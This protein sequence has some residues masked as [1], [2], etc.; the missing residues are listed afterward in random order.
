MAH[1]ERM[2]TVA[3]AIQEMA[4]RGYTSELKVTGSSLE[5]IGSDK[6][7]AAN[8]VMVREHRRFEGVSDPDDTSVLYAIEARD[9][10][11][12]VLVDGYGTYADPEIAEFLS[13][14]KADEPTVK[15]PHITQPP[16]EQQAPR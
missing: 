7:F 4:A 8:E 3:G 5:V 14:V 15:D 12:G 9:G 13:N 11:R 2:E 16:F 1:E 10:T 6:R